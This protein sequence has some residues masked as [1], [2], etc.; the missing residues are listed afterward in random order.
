M[1]IDWF[2]VCAQALNFVV[3]V[4]LLKRFLYK[5]IIDAID[6]REKR[7]AAELAD[8]DAKRAQAQRERDEFEHK[9]QEFEQQRAALF[10]KAADD[11]RTERQRLLEKAKQEAEALGAKRR[12]ALRTDAKAIDQA[13]AQRTQ[14]EVFEIARKVLADLAAETLEERMCEAFMR[15]LRMLDGKARENLRALFRTAAEP[16]LV[17][18]AFD[19][20]APQRAAIQNSLNEALSPEV[21]VHFE[22]APDLVCG[23]ELTTNGQKIAWSIADYISSLERNVI[24]ILNERDTAAHKPDAPN[25]EAKRQ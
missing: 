16:A 5:P 18:S 6:A 11:A 17:R 12:E 1:L 3:L 21:H 9:N 14:Q 4:W 19:L 22:T 7:I 20:P 10:S 2:T 8:A 24:G 15:R 25:P 13:V 23:I